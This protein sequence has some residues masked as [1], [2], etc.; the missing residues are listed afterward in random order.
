MS[1]LEKARWVGVVI[2]LVGLWAA[3]ML[4]PAEMAVWP[5]GAVVFH[6]INL[7]VL[8][9]AL[10]RFT[11]YRGG[12]AGPLYAGVA[13]LGVVMLWMWHRLSIQPNWLVVAL[14]LAVMLLPAMTRLA[15][16]KRDEKNLTTP[17]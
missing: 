17:Q 9:L 1:R 3:L 10:G 2:G 12:S 14:A 8:A 11:N 7:S 5:I 4:M 13:G 15:F 16:K 6:A